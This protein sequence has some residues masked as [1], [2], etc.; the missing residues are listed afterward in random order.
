MSV[1]KV[2]EAR[3]RMDDGKVESYDHGG[4]FVI[5]EEDN[6]GWRSPPWRVGDISGPMKH[7]PTSYDCSF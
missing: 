3:K 5:A 4:W 2:A 6:P 7:I 1:E